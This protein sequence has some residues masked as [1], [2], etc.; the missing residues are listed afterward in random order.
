MQL[1]PQL[2]RDFSCLLRV[3]RDCDHGAQFANAMNVV[4]GINRSDRHGKV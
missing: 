2:R 1:G 3:F 4:F